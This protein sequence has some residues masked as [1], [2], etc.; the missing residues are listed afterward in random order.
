MIFEIRKGFFVDA[1]S[2]RAITYVETPG[3]AM[4]ER[5]RVIVS[6]KD[7]SGFAEGNMAEEEAKIKCLEYVEKWKQ[8][9]EEGSF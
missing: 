5:W 6:V 2:I 3:E 4:K 9:K 8:A 1:D 7:G